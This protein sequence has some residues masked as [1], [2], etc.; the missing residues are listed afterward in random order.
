LGLK[1]DE[2]AH[3]QTYGGRAQYLDPPPP[4]RYFIYD[5]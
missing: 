5:G 3:Q 4:S 1:F 2:Y